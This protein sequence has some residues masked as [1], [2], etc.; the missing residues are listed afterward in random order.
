MYSKIL[1]RMCKCIHRY[2]LKRICVNVLKDIYIK[3][4]LCKCTQRY[5]LK[6]MS[7]FTQSYI[8]LREWENVLKDIY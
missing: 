8:Y 6:R 4:N 3:E 5:I 1:K 7:E 2:I